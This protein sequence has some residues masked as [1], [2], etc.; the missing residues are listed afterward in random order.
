MQK[1]ISYFR[2]VITV[3]IIGLQSQA[4]SL[5]SAIRPS[6]KGNWS[7]ANAH[8]HNDYQQIHPFTS[9]YQAN[10]GSMEADILLSRDTLFVGHGET[11]IQK[12]R[13]FSELYLDSLRFYTRINQGSIFGN[14]A[15][16]LQLLIDIKTAAEPT[17][18]ILIRELGKYPELIHSSSLIFVITENRPSPEK[19]NNYPL[20][21]WFDGDAGKFYDSATLRKVA[22]LSG[23][24]AS[25]S[26]WKANGDPDTASIQKISKIINEAHGHGKKIRFWN[27]PDNPESWQWMILLG[28]DW[29]NTD[30]ISALASF[31]N[32]HP[33]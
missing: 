29:I 2:I 10:F 9:A 8:S 7:V 20:F 22:M 25:F 23:N 28:V 13:L 21:I 4:Q 26:S 6:I 30:H 32:R 31:L 14:T 17:L 11:D 12:H 16:T 24:F 33:L 5:D 19:W 1:A 15:R 27:V 3:I 18:E